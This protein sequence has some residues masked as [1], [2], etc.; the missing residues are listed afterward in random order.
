M[1]VSG[2]LFLVLLGLRNSMHFKILLNLALLYT[3]YQGY[4]VSFPTGPLRKK[5]NYKPLTPI[6]YK[7]ETYIF[8]YTYYR[9]F[10]IILD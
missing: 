4:S 8:K 5:Y 3:V 1:R 7:D 2:K 9:V 10:F 6:D